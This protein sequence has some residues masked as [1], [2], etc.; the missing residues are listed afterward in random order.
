VART[1]REIAGSVVAHQHR[2]RQQADP[3][4]DR[5]KDDAG[6]AAARAGDVDAAHQRDAE[7]NQHAEQRDAEFEV[8]ID[9][10]RMLARGNHARQQQAAETHAAHEGAEQDAERDRR[11]ADD[12]LQQLKPDDF[13]NEGG[14]AAAD[15]EDDQS[16]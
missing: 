10:Q 4:D 9:A 15:E 3:G 7:Q 11:R 5:A 16:R 6:D 14:A 1:H 8:G 13:V 12:Q 2:R